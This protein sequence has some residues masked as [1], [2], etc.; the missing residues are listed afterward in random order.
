VVTFVNDRL[1][2]IVGYAREV[3]GKHHSALLLSED[4][5]TREYEQLWQDLRGG[6]T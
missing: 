3:I 6:V 5:E 4:V 2:A 1:L